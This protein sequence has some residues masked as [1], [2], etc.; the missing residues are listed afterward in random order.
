MDAQRIRGRPHRLWPVRRFATRSAASCCLTG[1]PLPLHLLSTKATAAAASLAACD[2]VE[3]ARSL[4][5]EKTFCPIGSGFVSPGLVF[6][7]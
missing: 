7:L 6:E 3:V 5:C 4:S 2:V 1:K